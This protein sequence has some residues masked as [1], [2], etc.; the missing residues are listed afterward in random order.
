MQVSMLHSIDRDLG[1]RMNSVLPFIRSHSLSTPEQFSRQFAN[2]SDASVV[3]IFLQITDEQREVLYESDILRSHHVPVL[4]ACMSGAPPS[5]ATIGETRWPVRVATRCVAVNGADLAVHVVEPLR[6]TFNALHEYLVYLMVI[7]PIALV[8]ATSAGYWMSRRALAPVEQIRLQ[9]AAIEP[10]DLTSRI[11]VPQTDDELA[12]LAQTLNAMLT[13]I[14]NGFRSI[15][16]FTAD[17]SHELRAPLA[18]IITA[19]EVSL[20]RERTREELTEV[21]KKTHREARRMSELVD[22]LLALAR[23]DFDKTRLGLHPF[24]TASLLRELCTTVAPTASAKLLRIDSRIPEEPVMCLGNDSDLRRLFLILLDNAVKYTER[25]SIRVSLQRGSDGI[26]VMVRDTGIGIDPEA[27][28]HI[29]DR[30]WRADKVRSR[31]EAGAGLGLSIA[32]QIANRLGGT[33]SVES[34]PGQ[35]STFT[36]ELRA[37]D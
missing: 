11:P 35:G 16:Q 2:S 4:P 24:D 26:T 36:V 7:I 19:A 12:R 15:E 5:I 1:Y 25:G 14:E 29:F 37:A 10:S 33:I 17:A 9:A 27:L 6:D 18:L 22:D 28:P 34:E 20:R 3:G 23:N 32:S 8:L 31:A 21:L 13:R 30:F